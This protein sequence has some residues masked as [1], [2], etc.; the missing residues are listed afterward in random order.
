MLGP[1]HV[2]NLGAL[3]L[4]AFVTDGGLELPALTEHARV[5]VRFLD[6]VVDGSHYFFKENEQAQKGVRRIGLGTMGL[7]D[8]LIALK[9]R[10][11]SEESLAIIEEIYRAIRDAAYDASADLAIEKGAF[12]KFERRRVLERPFI[13]R[14]PRRLQAKILT[15][16]LRNG[17]LLTQAPTGTTS[18][19]A[20]VSSG[21]EPVFDFT[22][23]RKDRLGE[24]VIEHPAYL[25]WKDAHPD[26]P[27]PP[28]FVTAEQLSPEEHVRVQAKIQE[29][30]DS[31]ISKTVNA[32]I[33]HT[34]ED[35]E[36]LYQLAYELGC[37][38]VTYYRDGSRD[39]VLTHGAA[40]PAAVDD[41][42]PRPHALS[43][44]TYRAATPLGTAFVT[45]NRAEAGRDG[46]P[47]EV[48]LN[49]GKAGSDVAAVAEA[50][51]RLCSLCLRLPAAMPAR[52]RVEAI[53]DQLGGIGGASSLGFGPSRV[54]SLPDALARVLAE[55]AGLAESEAGPE[56][57]QSAP[58]GTDL[59]PAC[60]QATLR[61]R[62]GCA[63][64]PCGY[65][66]C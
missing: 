53:V 23:V 26:E 25:A 43:G 21:I 2:C 47:F 24:R 65:S 34:V 63:S 56:P 62:E 33:S 36:R 30:T 14:L 29:F 61:H 50:L 10:Y 39:A 45:V 46:L 20:G 64:C 60:G 37:K 35:V 22:M 8:A 28:Y 49:V 66:A 51:G 4:A 1:W 41:L 42:L 27:L 7:A 59:C 11:G 15:R 6:N 3:N 40:T 19:L 5:A 58:R 52:A 55:A 17:V 54:R 44:T 16:G 57:R 48:F 9:V 13:A 12:P 18:L 38:G 32:P 31:S